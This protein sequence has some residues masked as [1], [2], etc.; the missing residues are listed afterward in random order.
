[1]KVSSYFAENPTNYQPVSIAVGVIVVIVVVVGVT[2]TIL[3]IKRRQKSM[4]SATVNEDVAYAYPVAISDHNHEG[5]NGKQT[6]SDGTEA[7]YAYARI[8]D[9]SQTLRNGN[10]ELTF[11][12]PAFSIEDEENPYLTP[13]KHK[14]SDVKPQGRRGKLEEDPY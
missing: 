4:K 11:D 1:L 6:S 9:P 8:T 7:P 14:S 12:N 5:L 3:Y 2:L 10:S 13:I